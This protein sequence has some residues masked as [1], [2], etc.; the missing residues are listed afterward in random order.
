[1]FSKS[2]NAVRAEP[3]L[4]LYRDLSYYPHITFLGIAFD[5]R[6]TFTKHFEEISERCNHKFHR[7]RILVTKKWGTS[8]ISILQIYK[9]CVRPVFKYSIVS[10][11]TVS[12]S[13]INKVQRVRIEQAS[14]S[15]SKICGGSLNTS[16]LD[17]KCLFVVAYLNKCVKP[18]KPTFSLKLVVLLFPMAISASWP[19]KYTFSG[20]ILLPPTYFSALSWTNLRSNFPWPYRLKNIRKRFR[21]GLK[22]EQIAQISKVQILR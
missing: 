2:Q 12:E 13:V 11:I 17:S 1:M 21:F 22:W 10:A 4:S 14:T 15:C 6:M 20:Q 3:A 19:H 8:P 7:L 5:T 18:T 16:L 9:Q